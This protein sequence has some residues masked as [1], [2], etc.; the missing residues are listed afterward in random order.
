MKQSGESTGAGAANKMSNVGVS[1]LSINMSTLMESDR[2]LKRVQDVLL[3]LLD[4]AK[5]VVS[6][7]H[8]NAGQTGR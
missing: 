6:T 5:Q 4:S 1:G 7:L 3:P 8:A 2:R